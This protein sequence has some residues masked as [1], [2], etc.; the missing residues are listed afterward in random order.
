MTTDEYLQS[1]I[2]MTYKIT[3]LEKMRDD[4]VIDRVPSRSFTYDDLRV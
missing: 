3:E 1:I 2:D 4:L